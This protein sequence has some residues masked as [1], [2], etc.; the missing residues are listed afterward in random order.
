MLKTL[1]LLSF[2]FFS[3]ICYPIDIKGRLIDVKNNEAIEF[4]SITLLRNDS[5]FVTEATSD[6]NGVFTIAGDFPR[7]DYLLRITYIGYNTNLIRIND[8]KNNINLGDIDLINAS[9]EINEVSVTANSIINKVDRQ[10][11]L[12]SQMEVKSSTDGFDLLSKIFLPGTKV[13]PI[14]RTITS[15]N[16][17]I[18]IRINGV[19]ATIQELVALKSEDINRIEYFQDPGIRFGNENVGAVV[20]LIVLRKKESGGYISLSGRDAPFV[21]FGDDQ[22]SIKANNKASE[23]SLNY[24]INY[25]GYDDRWGYATNQYNFPD[26][27]ITQIREGEKK[28]MNFQ[29]HNLNLN[30]N[31]TKSNKYMFNVSLKDQIYNGKTINA[32]NTFY[33]NNNEETYIYKKSRPRNNTPSLDIYYRQELKNK[34]SLTFNVVG[35]YIHTNNKDWYQESQDDI[36]LN[37]IYNRVR[38]EKYSII[39]EALYNKEFEKINFTVGAKHTQGYTNN[40]YSGT[41]NST[42]DMQ[43]ADSYIY[44]QIQGKI[45]NKLGYSVGIAGS[46]IWF[47]EDDK[48][49]TYYMLR[50]SLQLSYP[51]HKTLNMRYSFKVNTSTPLLSELSN[52]EQQTDSFTITR[53]NPNLKPYNT[54][55]NKLTFSFSKGILDI[56]VLLSHSY[57]H[58]P[59]MNTYKLDGNKVLSYPENYKSFYKLGGDFDITVRIIKDIWSVNAWTGSDHFKSK[60]QLNSNSYTNFYVG[61]QSNVIYRN[62]TFVCGFKSRYN[63][64]WGENISYGEKW[65]YAEFG[66]KYKTSKLAL[67]M[68]LPFESNWSVGNKNLSN[69]APSKSWVFIEENGHMLYL[70]FSCNVSFG[71][72]YKAQ[73]KKLNNSDSDTGILK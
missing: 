54:Y 4:A 42:N 12:P 1:I 69:V 67:G 14:N 48:D 60:G 31:L 9:Y 51:I 65:N 66:Y 32:S 70:R 73:E 45:K 40:K 49:K 6:R 30:Y 20:N 56:Q 72:K 29:R 24:S 11:I 16:E 2:L 23:F 21:E 28:P 22:I 26:N 52:V 38:G 7:Q 59:F 61:A 27:E 33:A 68:S 41:N 63:N 25:R 46:R 18:Q 17:E 39:G 64:L 10:I 55:E 57:M 15:K 35:T 47:K 43:N 8:L 37:S 58:K 3:I 19:K 50:P 13:D 62:Y 36:I 44:A 34:Q 71:R 5:T 53:G